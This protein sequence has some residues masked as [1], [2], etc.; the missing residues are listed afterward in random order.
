LSQV[1]A[2]ARDAL[3]VGRQLRQP[4]GRFGIGLRKGGGV[5]QA[6]RPDASVGIDR[7]RQT[8]SAVAEDR[9]VRIATQ[10]GGIH[11]HAIGVELGDI[12]VGAVIERHRGGVVQLRVERAHGEKIARSGGARQVGVALRVDR[13]RHRVFVAAAAQVGGVD[14]NRVDHQRHR[15]VVGA[16]RQADRAVGP[17]VERRLHVVAHTADELVRHRRALHQFAAVEM[18]AQVAHAVGLYAVDAGEANRDRV[19]VGAGMDDPVVLEHTVASV[20][21][22]IDA[23]VNRRVANAREMRHA[24]DGLIVAQVVADAGLRLQRLPHGRWV[25]ADQFHQRGGARLAG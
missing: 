20:I 1:R 25:G 3:R 14:Q 9:L 6:G 11:W 17:Q 19:R 4:T 21:F 22:K 10:V 7:N 12:G 8:G 23:A 16:E 18:Q 13:H 15:G 2:N 24:A 5:G